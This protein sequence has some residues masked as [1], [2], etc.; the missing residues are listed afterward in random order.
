MSFMQ[1]KDLCVH[2]PIRGGFF[3]TVVDHVY[4]VDGVS[5]E[6]EKGKTYGLVGESGSGKST[7]GKAIIGLEKITSGSIIYE[8]ENV[9]NQRRERTSPYNRDIQMIFQDSHSSM[10][11]RKRIKDIIAEP[12]RNFLKLSDQEENK[13]INE[14]L[15]IVGMPEDAKYKYPHE[16]SG[17]Q[18][19]RIGIARAVACNPKMIIA[20]EP[21][22]A[23]DLSVQAQVLN[24]MKDIQQEYG[25]SYLFISHDLGVVKHMCDHISIMYKGRFVETGRREDV[26]KN[27]QHIYTQR[28]LSAIPNIEPSTRIARKAERQGVEALYQTEQHKYY[29][30]NGKVYALK[31]LSST[32]SVAMNTQEK[33]GN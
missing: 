4:A 18:K 13:R 5:M 11:P 3:N 8:G 23:L 20:D 28:L 12:I 2:Y 21:V 31:Q 15:A 16:F 6:F 32:H 22:S 7:T 30:E 17:G 33:G 27:P 26:Y 24:F 1:I 9:T 25:L 29:D 10:N 19:Q 14:L